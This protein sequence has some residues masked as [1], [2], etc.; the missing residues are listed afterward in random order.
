MGWGSTAGVGEARDLGER[1][2]RREGLRK[3]R[4]V[5]GESSV[6]ELSRNVGQHEEGF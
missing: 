3:C 6:E 2:L 1:R 4:I 5:R